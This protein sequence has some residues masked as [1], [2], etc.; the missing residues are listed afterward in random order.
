MR[1]SS[2][3]T[4]ENTQSMR[5]MKESLKARFRPLDIWISSHRIDII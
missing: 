4:P 1:S 2:P 3:D 5:E